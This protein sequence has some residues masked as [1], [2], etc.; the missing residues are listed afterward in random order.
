M[1]KL[2]PGFIYQN[3]LENKFNGKVSASVLFV[4]IANSTYITDSY[5]QY[6]NKGAEELSIVFNE[7]FD[8]IIE[9]IYS[10]KGFIAGFAG[11]S[12][13]AV[14]E[15]NPEKSIIVADSIQKRIKAKAENI[16][17]QFAIP[18]KVKIGLSYGLIEWGILGTDNRKTYFFKG[19]PIDNSSLAERN[20]A[21]DNIVIDNNYREFISKY[22]N[23]HLKYHEH[24]KKEL[25]DVTN[26][27][28]DKKMYFAEK[29]CGISQDFSV[30]KN[31]FSESFK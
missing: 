3:F 31:F 12:V 22:K 5:L 18:I 14:F 7:I 11:D 19:E 4:D 30:V 6:G 28:I 16:E 23:F 2:L 1:H 21:P 24:N 20:C 8:V 9:I 15:K 25:F 10:Y 17:K 27:Q 26:I 13:T 29:H